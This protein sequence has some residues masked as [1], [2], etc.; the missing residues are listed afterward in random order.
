MGKPPLEYLTIWRMQ[1]AKRWLH[2]TDMSMGELAPRL[3]YTSED[4]FKRAFKRE[5]GTAPGAY[6]RGAEERSRA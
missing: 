5:V 1:L 3:G 6:R 4:A 2:Q